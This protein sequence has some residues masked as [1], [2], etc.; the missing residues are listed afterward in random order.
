MAAPSG[1]PEAPPQVLSKRSGRA[2]RMPR[3][4]VDYLPG[5][6]TPLAHMPK[7]PPR[8]IVPQQRDEHPAS[9]R[10]ES[11]GPSSTDQPSA[12]AFTTQPNSMGL[13]RVYPTR[14]TLIPPDDP[15]LVNLTD[16][17][18][19]EGQRITESSAI[20]DS[21][22]LASP[23]V[24]NEH[25]F[26]AF[27]NPSCGLLMAWQYSGSNTKSAAE[28][29][30]LATFMKDP[31]YCAEDVHGIT[32][33]REAKLLDDYLDDKANPFCEEH[34]WQQST[35][36]IRLP[37]ENVSWKSEDDAPELEIPGVYHRSLIDIITAV[38]EDDIAKTFN[39]TP[40][41]QY[42]KVSEE[43]T[44]QVFS[45]AHASPAM[46]DAYA[47]INALP[48][49]PDDNLERI[50]A[51]LMVWSDSTHLTNFGDAS[52]WPFYVYFGNQSK[53]T[54][55]KPTS[56]ACHHVAYIPTVSTNI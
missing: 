28:F 37:K 8:R 41:S 56:G 39:M 7:K 19:L 27:T 30:R 32:H 46:L 55:G 36:R 11:E 33:T 4:F 35:A 44:I 13:Y 42:W 31:L 17:P 1:Q 38:F 22:G 26:D 5:S 16:A 45:E 6:E 49:E 47:E 50:V 20:R 9:E 15:C 40:F 52:M 12:D 48:R 10:E 2:I 3:R 18:T 29:D 34:G 24:D 43:K 25:L 21:T 14:P 23:D 53:Y 51:S 54:R